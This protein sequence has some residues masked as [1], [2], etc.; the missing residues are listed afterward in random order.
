MAYGLLP[1]AAPLKY[2]SFRFYGGSHGPLA[3]GHSFD[4]KNSFFSHAVDPLEAFCIFVSPKQ[5]GERT[6]IL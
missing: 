4:G 1:M 2:N 6:S 5:K 3:I